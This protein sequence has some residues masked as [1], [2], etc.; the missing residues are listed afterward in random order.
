[1][2]LKDLNRWKKR[3]VQIL[4]QDSDL[5]NTFNTHPLTT[6]IPP[7]FKNCRFLN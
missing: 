2:V 6:L 1:M 3:I 5:N 4:Y 7:A